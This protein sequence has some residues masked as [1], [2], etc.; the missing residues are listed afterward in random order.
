MKKVDVK[1]QKKIGLE[2]LKEVAAFCEKNNINY[3]IS[4]GTLLGA[5]RHNGYIPWDDDI[6]IMMPRK[7]YNRF[8]QLFH[9]DFCKAFHI[10]NTKNYPY[11]F[12]KVADMKYTVM[13][14][15]YIIDETEDRGV[16]IDIFPIDKLPNNVISSF[17]FRLHCKM[18]YAALDNRRYTDFMQGSLINRII[19]SPFRRVAYKHPLGYWTNKLDKLVQKYE[20]LDNPKRQWLDCRKSGI[21]NSEWIAN[22][23]KHVFEDAEFDIPSKYDEIL[24]VF[25]DDYMKLPPEDQRRDHS[26]KQVFYREMN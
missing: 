15:P 17:F 10:E 12:I 16:E 21:I 20:Y 24:K 3:M 22:K 9:S 13:H 8:M 23:E 7:D 2:I 19:N 1:E 11:L 14:E 26:G 25:Y 4:Y 5:I 6:D 18:V